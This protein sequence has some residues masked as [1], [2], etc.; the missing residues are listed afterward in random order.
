MRGS[1]LVIMLV[2]SLHGAA[3][4]ALSAAAAHIENSPLLTTAGPF[5]MVHAAAG[6]ALAGV[7]ASFAAPPRW[8]AGAA[9]SLQAGV[10]LFSADLT[11]RAFEG[12][13]LFPYAAPIGGSLVIT[14]W[15]AIA[16]W[17]IAK[18]AKANGVG[19]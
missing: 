13:R 7:A 11:W 15:L 10:T 18:L 8:L 9:L 1:S 17:T 6:L 16:A 5:L 14:S 4:V 3:G 19:R 2:A 12:G